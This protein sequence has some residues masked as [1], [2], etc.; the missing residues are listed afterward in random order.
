MGNIGSQSFS[1]STDLVDLK[2]K[3]IIVTGGNRGIGLATVRH[4]ARAGAKV[5]LAARDESKATGAIAQLEHEGLGPGNGEVIWLKLDL[6]DPRDAKKG[7][8]EFLKRE[9]RLDIL[10]NNAA[11]M[12]GDFTIGPDGVATMVV[13]NYISPF[14]F[15]QTLIPLLQQTAKEN[16]SD[17][18]IVNVTSIMHKMVSVPNLKF[19][20]P[21]DFNLDFRGKYF[22]GLQRYGKSIHSYSKL[23]MS[24]WTKSLHRR[25]N[26]DK[27][28]PITVIAVHPG[29]VDTFSHNWPLPKITGFLARL[30]ISTTDVGA[31]TSVF[32][33]AGKKVADNKQVYQGAY[34]ENKP[35]GKIAEPYKAVL[36]EALGD[37]LW[38]TT[39]KFLGNI[40]VVV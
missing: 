24:L 17:V 6:S 5:Y 11:L 1:P 16:N 21:A 4:L 7:A 25:L 9:S 29:G 36:D 2:G 12:Q 39:V 15:T 37:Q 33:A 38:E 14:V 13:I 3:V 30:A 40:G 28:A 35:T 22:A 19:D 26:A 20:E 27:T 23:I 31:Y 10:V 8:E 34:L 32:A 18:R